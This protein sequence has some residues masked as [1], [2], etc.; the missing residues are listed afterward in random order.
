LD[1]GN[2]ENLPSDGMSGGEKKL[3]L[4][5]ILWWKKLSIGGR[6]LTNAY[7]LKVRM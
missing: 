6:I 5:H 3:L 4:V 2:R 1:K 7:R